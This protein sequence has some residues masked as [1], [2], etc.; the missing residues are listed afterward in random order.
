M[1][2][3]IVCDI[4]YEESLDQKCNKTKYI[5]YTIDLE[6]DHAGI[7]SN[8][9]EGLEYLEDFIQIIIDRDINLSFFVQAKLYK[10]ILSLTFH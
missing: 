2:A 5:C 7:L 3:K 8:Y 9:Y 6:E 1:K 10:T 4:E